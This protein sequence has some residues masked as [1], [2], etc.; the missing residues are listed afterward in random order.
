M[1]SILERRPQ[2]L[3]LLVRWTIIEQCFPAVVDILCD[4]PAQVNILLG[5]K[6]PAPENI[7]DVIN[8]CA[9]DK[10]L[11]VL[12]NGSTSKDERFT[13]ILVRIFTS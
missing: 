6:S 1:I 2:P 11:Q 8:K 7:D 10:D 5:V 12:L 13:E 9:A 4:D 3:H